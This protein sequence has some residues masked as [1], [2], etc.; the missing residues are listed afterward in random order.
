MSINDLGLLPA[1]GMTKAVFDPMVLTCCYLHT[2][3]SII[4]RYT[5]CAWM[6]LGLRPQNSGLGRA[7]APEED[8]SVRDCMS[9]LMCLE[10]RLDEASRNLAPVASMRAVEEIK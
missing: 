1:Y 4:W 7:A 2:A 3:Y 10:G 8:L 6:A 9:P 5:W